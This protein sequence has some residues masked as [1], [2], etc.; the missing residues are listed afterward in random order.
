MNILKSL[1]KLFVR[2]ELTKRREAVKQKLNEQINRTNSQ[3]V[4]ARNLAYL[5]IIEQL[6]GKGIDVV[7]KA[8]DKI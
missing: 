2:N 6:D 8:I 4:I 3:N 5:A 1:L 7:E